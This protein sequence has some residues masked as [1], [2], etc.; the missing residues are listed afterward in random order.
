[1]K[2]LRR[3]L[4]LLLSLLLVLSLATVASADGEETPAAPPAESTTN[5]EINGVTGHTFDVHKLMGVTV[6]GENFAYTINDTYREILKTAT[7]K[8][9]DKE[10]IEYIGTL[11]ESQIRELTNNVYK[12]IKSGKITPEYTI[13]GTQTAITVDQ[14]YYLVADTTDLNGQESTANSLA[15]VDTVGEDKVTFDVK[16][17]APTMEKKV[18]D[19]QDSTG[20]ERTY[21][22]EDTADHDIGDR[23]PYLITMTM[24]SNLTDY[25]YYAMYL[26]DTLSTGLT[27]N[28]DSLLVYIGTTQSSIAKKDSE[29]ASSAKF[30][31]EFSEGTLTVYPNY[32]YQNNAGDDVSASA[33]AGGDVKKVI[34]SGEGES[35]VY[36]GNG[37]AITLYYSCTLNENAVVGNPGN[38]NHAQFFY[39][40]NPYGD[41]FGHTPEDW[42]IVF[43]YKTVINKVDNSAAHAPLP[44]AKFTLYK[45][46]ADEAGTET[47]HGAKGN[48]VV[49]AR[50]STNVSDNE[51]TSDVDESLQS[52]TF[53]FTG[54]D[55]GY[56]KLVED[57]APDGYNKIEDVYFTI[58]ATHTLEINGNAEA[59][60][61]QLTGDVTTGAITLTPDLAEGSLSA[62][63]V[64]QSG[65]ELPSTGGMGTT[66]FY[67]IGAALMLGAA[68]L[69]ITKRRMNSEQ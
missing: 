34:V 58:T 18:D 42:C 1:M 27:L 55:D 6:S 23:V 35:A 68:V 5:L 7:D 24:P 52:T 9:T 14:G 30:L 22:W 25:S 4:C 47:A 20:K 41:S 40:N 21:D 13:S 37:D 17:Y 57:V 2:H 26:K 66:L 10:I 50:K 15:M 45:F 56:Y 48:W 19:I 44:G 32:G 51:N 54:L 61:T 28:E 12:A 46:T 33:T 3:F 31:W 8:E 62:S 65:T 69:L 67:I 63:V 16:L 39:S 60:L 59:A 53:T 64:N 11:S 36:V 43:T 49:V 38:P 29:K